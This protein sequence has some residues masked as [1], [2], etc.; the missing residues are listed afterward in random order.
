MQHKK[1]Q[2][3]W[4]KSPCFDHILVLFPHHSGPLVL[5]PSSH[6]HH[7]FLNPRCPRFP[8]P[9]TWVLACRTP[10]LPP[11]WPPQGQGG[12]RGGGGGGRAAPPCSSPGSSPSPAGWRSGAAA[13]CSPGSR[14]A[15]PPSCSSPPPPPRRPHH[16]HPRQ[17]L[18]HELP[19]RTS[20]CPRCRSPLHSPLL[21]LGRLVLHLSPICE[22]WRLCRT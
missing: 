7:F 15:P 14:T 8:S 2:Q 3:L 11:P 5:C 6:S 19:V 20:C 12:G 17:A 4:C 18:L 22:G 10:C 1:L 21:P 13:P 16:H 9:S